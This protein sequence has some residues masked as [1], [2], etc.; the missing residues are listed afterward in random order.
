MGLAQVFRRGSQR[1]IIMAAQGASAGTYAL[2]LYNSASDARLLGFVPQRVGKD[3]RFATQG[4]LPE[5]ASKYRQLVVTRE[6]VAGDQRRP[7]SRPGQIVL[8]GRLTLG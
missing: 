2:W 5:N 3:G 8:Q 1:A 6:N 7:P 4:V